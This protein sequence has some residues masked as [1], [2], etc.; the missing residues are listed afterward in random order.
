[1]HGLINR[2]VQCF[3]RDIYGP[4]AWAELAAS[5]GVGIEGFEAMLVYEDK[6]TEQLVS[7]L[8]RLRGRPA[9]DILEDLGTYLVTHE[10]TRAIRRLLRFG[11]ETFLEFLYSL[12]D[13]PDRARLAVPEL[14]LPQLRL[15]ELE[16][17]RYIL[18]ASSHHIGFGA[19]LVGILRALADD[20][21]TLA[22]LELTGEHPHEELLAIELL[23][24]DFAEGNSFTL[25]S[26][27]A[28]FS[29]E[30]AA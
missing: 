25:G 28:S 30:G 27:L 7:D 14:D 12:D 29:Q 11:G 13:L 3:V 5:V 8:A 4:Q 2:A 18:H 17:G 1:M 24:A 26:G 16:P 22:L 9:S 23:D 21:G 15:S 10:N 19:V 20:Y 6:V